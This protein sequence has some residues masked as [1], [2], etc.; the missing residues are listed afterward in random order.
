MNRFP[1]YSSIGIGLEIAVRCRQQEEL[2]RI[3]IIRNDK[4]AVRIT[5]YIY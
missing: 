1:T 4:V 2:S 5:G 3:P